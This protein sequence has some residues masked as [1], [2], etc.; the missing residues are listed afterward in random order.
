MLSDN[1]NELNLY[2]DTKNI[3]KIKIL[4]SQNDF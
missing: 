2:N 4:E 3:F 1:S